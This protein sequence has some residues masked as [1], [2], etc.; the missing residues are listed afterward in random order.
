MLPVSLI[1]PTMNEADN[2]VQVLSTAHEASQIIVVD[3]GSTDNTVE[4]IKSAGH[5]VD[6]IVDHTPGKGH[7]LRRGFA[8]ATQPYVVI[9]D[10]DGSMDLSEM[11]VM[12]DLLGKGYDVVKGSRKLGG[13]HDLTL[14]RALGNRGLTAAFNVLYDTRHTDL[15][16]GF[17]AMQREALH[18]M[19]LDSTG[20]EIESEL[21]ARSAKMNLDVTEFPS[22]EYPR[23]SG[24][25]NLK[26]IRDGWRVLSE[27]WRHR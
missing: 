6:I 20:F 7:A 8:V 17:I 26:P 4:T 11:A 1:I 21:I 15:C 19:N 16:Y 23:L 22:F 2:I 27:I 9:A 13:S 3:G 25:S 5:E 10:G 14:W 24:K 12:V 18:R